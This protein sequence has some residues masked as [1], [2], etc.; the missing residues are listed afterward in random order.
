MK[1][2]E[3]SDKQ[4]LGVSCDLIKCRQLQKKKA[5]HVRFHNVTAFYNQ[6]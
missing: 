3:A 6:Q 1:I 5:N 4:V 2:A